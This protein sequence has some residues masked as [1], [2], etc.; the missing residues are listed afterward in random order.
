MGI[1][2]NHSYKVSVLVDVGNQYIYPGFFNNEVLQDI[3][4]WHIYYLMKNV[5]VSPLN[6]PILITH[7]PVFLK[8]ALIKLPQPVVFGRTLKPT[9]LPLNCEAINESEPIYAIGAG[10]TEKYRNPDGRVRQALLKE[11]SCRSHQLTPIL[12]QYPKVSSII[13]SSSMDGPQVPYLGDSGR[14][15]RHIWIFIFNYRSFCRKKRIEKN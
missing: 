5:Q 10:V 4:E 2:R 6:R 15:H 11:T 8:K 1:R 13:C 3:G 12:S 14:V 7:V 9:K